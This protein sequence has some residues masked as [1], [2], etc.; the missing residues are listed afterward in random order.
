MYK[1][2]KGINYFISKREH[3]NF[4]FANNTSI[5]TKNI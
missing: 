4:H 5:Q 1:P 2:P 3:P